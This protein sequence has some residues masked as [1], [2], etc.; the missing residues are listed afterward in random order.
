[1]LLLA[2]PAPP[3]PRFPYTTLF[4]SGGHEGG[5]RS[6]T[7][8]TAGIVGFG[9]AAAICQREM[10]EESKRLGHLRDKLKD[11]LQRELDEVFINGTR[12]EEHT[13]ELQSRG[14]LVCRL[15]LE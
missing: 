13:P 3:T 1:S 10:A 4:R 15:L 7:L 6:G 2:P 9:E 14:H 5:M 11:T 12:S 8:N